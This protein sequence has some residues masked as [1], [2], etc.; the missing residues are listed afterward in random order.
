MGPNLARPPSGRADLMKKIMIVDDEYLIRY[1]LASF[2]HDSGTE[3]IPVASGEA[4]FRV[5]RNCRL[6]LCFL[7]IHLPDMNGLDIMRKF[8]DISPWTRIIIITGSMITDAM[9]ASIRENAHCL[10]SKP[11]DLDQVKAAASRVL[12]IGRPPREED[13]IVRGSD[14][15]SVQWIADDYRKH[16]RNPTAR[17]I[18]CY[19]VAPQGDKNEVL[20]TADVFDISESGMGL[21]TT[22]RLQPGHLIRLSDGSVRGTAVVRWSECSGAPESYRAGIQFVAPENIPHLVT[23]TGP[24]RSDGPVRDFSA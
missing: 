17:R 20:V 21:M 15:A 3:A 11:F 22:C 12:T 9:M 23:S 6:D 13:G 16:L 7:D 19:A 2:F 5:V 14:S 8:R 4:A 10:I 18:T 1:S 24:F